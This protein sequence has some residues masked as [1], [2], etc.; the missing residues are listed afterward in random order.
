[1]H[2]KRN[3]TIPVQGSP[4]IIPERCLTYYTHS[5]KKINQGGTED[6]NKIGIPI[7]QEKNIMLDSC[8]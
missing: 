2:R 8:Y 4:N 3:S 1:M 7:N 6:T 5:E